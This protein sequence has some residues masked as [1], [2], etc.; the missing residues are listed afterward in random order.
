[1][2]KYFA[3][4]VDPV[5]NYKYIYRY[6]LVQIMI[7]FVLLLALPAHA[8]SVTDMVGREV[9][10]PER[11]EGII[12]TYRPATYFLFALGVQDRLFTFDGALSGQEL[13]EQLEPGFT[14]LPSPKG[15]R[16]NMEEII[17]LNPD[18]VIMSLSP[19][20]IEM[21]NRLE[22]HNIATVIIHPEGFSEIMEIIEMLG[23]VLKQEEEA[24]SVLR[25]ME[26]ILELVN[27][28]AN[29]PQEDRKK[30]YY[31]NRR[32]LETLGKD[33]L[34]NEMIKL[35]GGMN[36]AAEVGKGFLNIS[37]EEL[38]QWEPEMVIFS[39][40]FQDRIEW[41]KEDP[42]YSSLSALQKNNYLQFPSNLEPWDF[43]TPS[44]FLGLLW[45][46]LN[47]HPHLYQDINFEEMVE[48]YYHTLYGKDYSQLGG[49]Y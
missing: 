40:F 36:L 35:A 15:G 32:F 16:F 9:T 7:L 19:E 29:L 27:R 25:G 42:R 1:M 44:A 8:K 28:T 5:S 3:K 43:P 4:E 46:S 30:V 13:L 24:S 21:A 33:M 45:L 48:D 37:I 14:G 34:Q 49:T 20:N 10:I 39:Q 26:K 18:L 41:L 22:N 6:C 12:S 23:F 11:V 2:C 31:A 17:L 38:L 47:L